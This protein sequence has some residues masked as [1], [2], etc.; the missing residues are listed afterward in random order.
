MCDFLLVITIN[1]HP[2]SHCFPFIAVYWSNLHFRQE[3]PPFNTSVR[4]RW[5]P[6]LTITKFGLKY[7]NIAL[8]CG[9]V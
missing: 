3:V 9:V 1:L 4:A 2:I 5:T 8:S 7:R 6:K